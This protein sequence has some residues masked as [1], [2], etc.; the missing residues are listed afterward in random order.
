MKY[1]LGGIA[2]ATAGTVFYGNNLIAAI[3]F[4]RLTKK[5]SPIQQEWRVL[6]RY[7]DKQ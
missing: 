3:L 4:F 1:I 5:W 7:M 6:E 2:D